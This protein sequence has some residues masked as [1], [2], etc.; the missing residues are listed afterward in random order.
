MRIFLTPAFVSYALLCGIS[1]TKDGPAADSH[2]P[3]SLALDA[4]P[5]TPA[6]VPLN[7]TPVPTAAIA[8]AINPDHAPPYAG[9]T[10]V[11]E[12]TVYVSG[13][14]APPLMG[15]TYDKCRDAARMYGKTFREGPALPDGRRPLADAVVAV[16]GYSGFVAEKREAEKL[17][18]VDCAYSARTIVMTLGQRIEIKNKSV[19]LMFGPA[20]ENQPA[21][22]LMMATPGSD[23]VKLYP[24]QMGRFRIIDKAGSDWMEADVYVLG[25][26]LHAA[27]DERGHFRIEGVP[28][29]KLKVGVRHPFLVGDKVQDVDVQSS[30]VATVEVTLP[31]DK[32]AP[33]PPTI[34]DAPVL[35]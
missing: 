20:L 6:S 26:P 27:T 12:G 16:T 1:C 7:T 35:P 17:D 18:I 24:A 8:D 9:P 28:V 14:P 23:A 32:D 33:R 15:K 31:H 4:T 2:K 21:P 34:R 13:P 19:G 25:H 11:V 29:G 22:A 10:G 5:A 3:T 30:T